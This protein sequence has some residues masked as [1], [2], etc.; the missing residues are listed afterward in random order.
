MKRLSKTI[1]IAAILF[2][3]AAACPA[4]AESATVTE[5][6]S[7]GQ[8]AA[9][10]DSV[11]AGDDYSGVTVRLTADIDLKDADWVPIGTASAPFGGKFN[12]AGHTVRGLKV[13]APQ[14]SAVPVGTVEYSGAALFLILSGA[15]AQ[16]ANLTVEGTVTN[17]RQRSNLLSGGIVAYAGPETVIFNC[18]N[19]ASVS[20]SGKGGGG[21]FGDE[22]HAIAGGVV[23]HLE[24]Y[25]VSCVNYGAV[26]SASTSTYS[27]AGGLAGRVKGYVLSSRNEG[28]VSVSDVGLVQ[29]IAGG[30]AGVGEGGVLYD[31]ANKGSI[32]SSNVG[33]GVM[34]FTY[35]TSIQNALNFGSVGGT[36]QSGGLIISGGIIGKAYNG[37]SAVNCA[38]MGAVG[39]AGTPNYAYAGGIAGWCNSGPNSVENVFSNCSNS[40]AVSGGGQTAA[41]VGGL[42]GEMGKSLLTNSA[43]SG[44][45]DAGGKAFAGGLVGNKLS[46][47]DVS[48][49]VYPSGYDAVA[50]GTLS[51]RDCVPLSG[52]RLAGFVTTVIPSFSAS[53]LTL[54]VGEARTL[55]VDLKTYPGTP[56]DV[57]EFY[58]IVSASAEPPACLSVTVDGRAVTATGA[59]KGEA[60]LTAQIAGYRSSLDGGVDKSGAKTAPLSALAVV[61]DAAASPDVPPVWPDIPPVVSP[62]VSPVPPDGQDTPSERSSSS[63]CT[64]A[65][66]WAF[67]SLITLPMAVYLYRK[68]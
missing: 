17:T 3:A 30:V 22:D 57:G 4:G 49:S 7:A 48:D 10:R 15:H 29:N 31:A 26:N 65:G 47:A 61:N 54:A 63:G 38:N 44:A 32:Y 39:A 12:G 34:G 16:I 36:G 33:G 40:A 27:I 24:G 42:I 13:A 14:S 56:A 41:R 62:D 55:P 60:L 11:N 21:Y 1:Y 20:V 2:L 23:A 52:A 50:Y 28:A 43:N 66:G 8:L 35:G 67:V 64:A 58:S 46:N 59:A 68:K 9:F 19:F 5:I 53:Y 45:V 6:G 37:A 18:K 25:A 51:A